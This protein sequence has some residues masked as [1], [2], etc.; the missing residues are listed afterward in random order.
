MSL[1]EMS[2]QTLPK[3]SR[4]Q[5]SRMEFWHQSLTLCHFL[6]ATCAWVFVR[7]SGKWNCELEKRFNLC[8]LSGRRQVIFCFAH[9]STTLARFPSL[10]L[11]S[12]FKIFP[13]RGWKSNLLFFSHEL[14]FSLKLRRFS[15]RSFRGKTFSFLRAPHLLLASSAKRL[16]IS[17]FKWASFLTIA[18]FQ[19]SVPLRRAMKAEK[20]HREKMSWKT[21]PLCFWRRLSLT[22]SLKVSKAYSW[23]RFLLMI[24]LH[25]RGKTLRRLERS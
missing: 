15:L 25:T 13:K 17:I 5:R 19:A 16:R 9:C 7:M 3:A 22:L 1:C 18:S 12:C 14:R 21:H 6:R 11:S 20:A 10:S 8:I 23:S 24:K 2:L 4:K